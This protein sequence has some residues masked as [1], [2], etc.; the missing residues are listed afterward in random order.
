M[1]N[2]HRGLTVQS[3]GV[4]DDA[5]TLAGRHAPAPAPISGTSLEPED[6]W[7]TFGLGADGHEED[8]TV[9]VVFRPTAE[10]ESRGDEY[11]TAPLAP[12]FPLPE[13]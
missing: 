11:F 1:K 4:V 13:R 9:T 12:L 3:A 2:K 7:M 6:T 8:R 5:A 10:D